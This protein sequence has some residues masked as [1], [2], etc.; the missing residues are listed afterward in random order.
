MATASRLLL[1]RASDHGE[2]PPSSA[3]CC[4]LCNNFNRNAE[5]SFAYTDCAC[6]ILV[7]VQHSSGRVL[8]ARDTVLLC[9]NVFVFRTRSF[10]TFCLIC[11]GRFS[12]HF[13]PGIPTT[14]M[15]L[16]R[17]CWYECHPDHSATLSCSEAAYKRFCPQLHSGYSERSGTHAK[18]T[19]R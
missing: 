11:A 14:T 10:V 18:L 19:L 15:L 9:L 1:G 6:R 4:L 17:P 8:T 16:R 7:T 2:L 3:Y 13:M 12:T 5:S